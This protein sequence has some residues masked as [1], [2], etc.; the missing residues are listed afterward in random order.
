[1]VGW[2]GGW[3]GGTYAEGQVEHGVG[4]VVGSNL[5]AGRQPG[6]EL[7]GGGKGSRVEVE[8]AGDVALLFLDRHLFFC[9]EKWVGGWVDEEGV[10]SYIAYTLRRRR[11]GW[12]GGLFVYLEAAAVLLR[13]TVEGHGNWWVGGWVGGWFTYLEAAVVLLSVTVQGH[14]NQVHLT[15]VGLGEPQVDG[16]GLWECVGG[17]VRREEVCYRALWTNRGEERWV[18]GRG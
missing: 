8:H 5:T 15:G 18:G 2:V 3:V 12:V 11:S 14:G 16:E 4:D 13:V 6:L 10:K 17:W 9:V 1:M 7:D